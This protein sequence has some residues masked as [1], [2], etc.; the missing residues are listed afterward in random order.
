MG[1]GVVQAFHSVA[2]LR[3]HGAVGAKYYGTDG[4]LATRGGGAGFGQGELH[5]G[6][7]RR[8]F[9]P[10]PH[11]EALP[12]GPPPRAVALGTINW[13]SALGRAD[14]DLARSGLALPNA[15]TH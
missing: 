3:Q 15:L 4:H 5:G 11:Q 2:G 1:R 13:V 10:R 12:P 7:H 8:G 6:G 14:R 9:A